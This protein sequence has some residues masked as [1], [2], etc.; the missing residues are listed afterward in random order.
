MSKHR[1]HKFA[2][3]YTNDGQ[4]VHLCGNRTYRWS[5]INGRQECCASSWRK[6]NCKHCLKKR[7][8]R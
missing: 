4:S 2:P 8:R 3:K 7:T 1:V 6:V 5:G